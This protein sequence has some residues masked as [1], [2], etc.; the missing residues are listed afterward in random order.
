MLK[1]LLRGIFSV[2]GLILGYFISEILLTIPQVDNLTYISTTIT[3]VLFIIIISFIF[4]LIF[5]IISPII[6]KGISNLI[7]YI[8]KSMQKMSIT[9]IIYG[10]FG[11]VIA[12]ILM[13]FIAKPINDINIIGP[14]LLILLNVLAA[15]IGAEIMIKKKEDITALLVNMKKPVIKEKKVKEVIKESIKGIPKVL[16]TS[17]IIDGRIFDICET[18]FVEG[19]LVIPN[20]VLD[21]LRHISDSSDSLKR[22]RGRRGLDIL[23]KIQKELAIETQIVEDDFPKIAEVDAK[24]LK[25]AQKMEGKVITNDYNLNKVAEFQGVPVLNINELSNAIK[26][27]VLPGEEMTIDIVKDGKESSQ[28]VAY[29]EDGTMIVVEGGRKYIGQ[30]TSVI[31]TSVLQTAAGRMIFAKPKDN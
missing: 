15:I 21:E 14:I 30:T 28:G 4:G 12:L 9:E 8:E 17:V 18:G 6:Y 23:N 22:N 25:L 27:V 19:P 10:T 24:L 7:E 29:L 3:R 31:V 1:R 26:P 2:I 13:T 20:F 16:D 11:A 5:Y